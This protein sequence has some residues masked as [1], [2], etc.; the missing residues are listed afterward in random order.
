[1]KKKLIILSAFLLFGIACFIKVI[2]DTGVEEIWMQMRQFKLIHFVIFLGLSTLN[3]M[4]YNLRWYMI[5]KKI[6]HGKLSFWQL[7]M[8]RMSA[9]A[10]SYVTP[11]AQTG[12]EPL[13]AM[14][15]H[16]DGVPAGTSAS[17]VI[18]DKGLEF[19]AL[20]IFIAAGLAVSLLYGA[21][22]P[23]FRYAAGFTLVVIL[24]LIFWFYYSSVKDI[25]FFS[26]ILRGLRLNKFHRVKTFEEK[27]IEV[28][29]EMAKFY[30]KHVKTFIV[31]VMISFIITSFLLLE[32]YLIARFMGV[33]L[34]FMQT[35]LVSTIPYIAYA[36]PIPGGIGLLEG[37]TAVIFSAM[38]VSINAFVLVLIIRIR[39]LVFVLI[40]L[41]HASKQT[42]LMVKK[43][44]T[45]KNNLP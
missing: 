19:A 27:I 39:D 41:A 3:F 24:G 4:L 31:L 14:L 42:F 8:H 36:L 28:E 9:F 2:I 23:E 7:F 12:G 45:V 5:I 6:Y 30:S 10:V 16:D 35:F 38:G 22:P 43:A 13:R 21:L 17:S 25:G 1:M 40:G 37:S 33:E 20:A 26:S 18:I 32:H 11:S 34:D 15:L 29:V 44:F